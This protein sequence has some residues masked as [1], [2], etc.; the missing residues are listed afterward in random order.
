[1]KQITLLLIILLSITSC[2]STKKDEVK[3]TE[4]ADLAVLPCSFPDASTVKAPVWVCEGKIDGLVIQ[5]MGMS[6]NSAAGLSHQRQLALLDG[7]TILAAQLNT[8]INAAVT[9][10]TATRGSNSEVYVAKSTKSDL[11]LS[12]DKEINSMT[13][14]QSVRSPNGTYYVLVGLNK[15]AY[16]LN[17]KTKV[18]AS[19]NADGQLWQPIT[20]GNSTD[21]LI[22]EI[23]NYVN[24]S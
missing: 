17:I 2:S 1:M 24:K 23:T 21:D 10:L 3:P 22:N 14:Y 6:Q 9:N 16:A 12:L 18:R 4:K 11:K 13:I 20:Q 8:K 15:A 5:A 19:M 7:Q